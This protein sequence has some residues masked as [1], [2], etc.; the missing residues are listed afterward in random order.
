MTIR[1]SI[2]EDD[3]ATREGFMKILQHAEDI[4]CIA[5]Y[6]T[7]EEA[8]RAIPALPPDVLLSDINLPGRS[9]IECVGELKSTHPQIQILMLTVYEDA[10][11]IFE[12]LRAG[13]S[14]YLLKRSA[15]D[16]LV[17]AIREVWQGGS[18]MS[19]Q[20]A[21]KVVTHFHRSPK[22]KEQM[23]ALSNREKEILDLLATGIP[24]KQI[25][26][27]LGIAAGTVHSHLHNIYGKLH[28]QSRTE[29][30]VKFLGR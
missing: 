24:Y 1:V 4:V 11:R 18:P 28:V 26:E 30:V 16:E 6:A 25:G 3:R 2:I 12:S 9:G 19:A 13:A 17:V 14:G 5:S 22:A 29:A 23:E 27:K 8:L 10:D 15:P 7:A 21:R 20:I